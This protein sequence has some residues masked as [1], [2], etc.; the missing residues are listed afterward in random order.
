MFSEEFVCAPVLRVKLLHEWLCILRQTRCE[1]H[2]LVVLMHA[3]EELR[4]VRSDEH[5]NHADL[6][7][8]FNWQN[9]V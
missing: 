9:D 4:N 5:I 7:L 6:G 8:N 1:D 2:Q 3:F